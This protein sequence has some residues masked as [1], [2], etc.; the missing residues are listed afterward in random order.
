MRI[1]QLTN[2][3][4]FPLLDGGCVA[5]NE[6]SKLLLANGSE[7][8]NISFATEKHPF[9]K[10][11]FPKEFIEK[12]DPEAI[13]IP[14]KITIAG[15]LKNLIKGTSYNLTRFH[16]SH[17]EAFL[18]AHL[19]EN[20]YELIVCE[21]IYILPYLPILR[22]FSSAKI[23]VRTHNVEHQ[24][25]HRLAATSHFPKSIYLKKLA[26]DLKI[27]ELQLLKQ[28]DGIL[29]I[30][31][32]D[33]KVFEQLGIQ[34]KTEVIA[35]SIHLPER[36]VSNES[37]HFHH[38][39]SM[40]W[41]PNIEA[42]AYLAQHLFPK[43][44][45]IIPTAEL[46]LSGSFFPENLK[47]NSKEG[48][49]VHGFVEDRFKF[50]EEYGIQLVPLKSGSG[51]RIKLLESMA[52]GTPIVTTKIG[53]EGIETCNEITLLISENDT[54]FVEHALELYKNAELRRQIGDNARNLIAKNYSFERINE[55][56][57]EFIKAIS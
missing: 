25:W 10:A 18:E 35:V 47:T 6:L 21:S 2:K 26:K 14:T 22:K 30:S 54:Q 32:D 4:I 31:E 49:F 36:R 23:V 8:K 1:L 12:F 56:F 43:I 16:S 39:G 7:V 24:I 52:M 29:A 33:K 27:A 34:T 40:N 46:H 17:V 53:A 9:N 57:I 20:Y 28:V 55:R 5:M 11:N 44:R 48:I 50:I 45:S 38:L 15:A 51:V 3:P 19:M 42:V 41:Q 37:I 13:E